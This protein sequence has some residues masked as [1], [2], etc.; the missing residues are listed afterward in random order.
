MEA[1]Q[2]RVDY[3]I[4]CFEKLFVAVRPVERKLPKSLCPMAERLVVFPTHNVDKEEEELEAVR[5][6]D[7]NAKEP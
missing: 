7:D 1:I 3:S 4:A 6:V 5:V 2:A